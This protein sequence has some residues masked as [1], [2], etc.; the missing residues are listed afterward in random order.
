[1]WSYCDIRMLQDD[2]GFYIDRNK[3]LVVVVEDLCKPT[4]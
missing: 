4:L 2:S 1:M 3:V